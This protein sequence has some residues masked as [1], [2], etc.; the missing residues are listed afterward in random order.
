MV[1]TVSMM[2]THA[3]L[4]DDFLGDVS[5]GNMAEIAL[6]QLAADRAQNESVKQFAQMMVTDHTAAATSFRRLP[7]LK[8]TRCRRLWTKNISRR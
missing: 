3:K 5:R 7:L 6:S 4:A 2:T 1:L 8:A